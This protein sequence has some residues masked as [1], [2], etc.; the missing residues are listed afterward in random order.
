MKSFIIDTNCLIS[1][2]TDRNQKQQQIVKEVIE[3]ASRNEINLYVIS[4]V[5]T[6]LVYVLESVYQTDKRTISMLIKDLLNNP[7]IIYN[8]GYFP[9]VIYKIWPQLIHDYGDAVIASASKKLK[10]S[11]YTFDRKFST[12]LR[13]L[14]IQYY[15]LSV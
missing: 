3:K 8:H 14:N 9:E 12:Q 15:L 10:M 4:N 6:E 5:L 13:K 2:I 11:V 1:F 7:G